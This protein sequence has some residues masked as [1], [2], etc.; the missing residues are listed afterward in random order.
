VNMASGSNEPVTDRV[1]SRGIQPRELLSVVALPGL[2]VESSTCE[3]SLKERGVYPMWGCGSTW[4][5][6]KK[7][8]GSYVA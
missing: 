2:A 7:E 5:E 4:P 6:G 1:V 3:W 8:A